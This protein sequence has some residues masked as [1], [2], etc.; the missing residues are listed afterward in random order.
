MRCTGCEAC[1][2][3]E[4]LEVEAENCKTRAQI[5]LLRATI[6]TQ[7][8]QIAELHDCITD[9]YKEV[10]AGTANLNCFVAQ[11]QKDLCVHRW[12]YSTITRNRLVVSTDNQEYLDDQVRIRT[13]Y[14]C[15]KEEDLEILPHKKPKVQE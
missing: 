4:F 14:R 6:K 1:Q 8:D 3:N 9:N 12:D 2:C 13:C 7:S 10:A 11:Q 15:D 5:E